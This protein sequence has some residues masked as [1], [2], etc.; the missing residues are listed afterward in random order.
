MVTNLTDMVE[1]KQYTAKAL[2]D[3]T[4]KINCQSPATYRK[5]I[6]YLR[7]NNAIHHTYQ[8]ND[9]YAF[10]VI[11]HTRKDL[12]QYDS[13]ID[14]FDLDAGYIQLE[15]A[16]DSSESK[17]DKE[18]KVNDV[19]FDQNLDNAVEDNEMKVLKETALS[20]RTSD[21]GAVIKG[22]RRK[23]TPS[24]KISDVVRNKI[25]KQ[26][27]KFPAQESHYRREDTVK[28]C[29]DS[30]L[31]INKRFSHEKVM[32]KSQILKCIAC[33]S[34]PLGF[35]NQK[36]ATI[37]KQLDML[38]P[39]N[40]KVFWNNLPTR[41]EELED[42]CDEGVSQGHCEVYRLKHTMVHLPQT[43]VF[44]T[45]TVVQPLDL[46]P[47]LDPVDTNGFYYR[48]IPPKDVRK[49]LVEHNALSLGD[50]FKFIKPFDGNRQNLTHCILSANSAFQLAKAGQKDPL[51]HYVFTKLSHNVS[52]KINFEEITSWQQLKDTLKSYYSIVKNVTQ[53]HEELETIRQRPNET[54]TEY[55]KKLDCIKNE[56]II[57]ENNSKDNH[58]DEL[59]AIKRLIKI[60]IR[61]VELEKFKLPQQISQIEQQPFQNFE[62]DRV[63]KVTNSRRVD[64]L[65]K[66]ERES[67]TQIVSDSQ[68]EIQTTSNQPF[69]TKNYRYPKI[70]EEEVKK[71]NYKMLEQ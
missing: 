7:E 49:V 31:S 23:P 8:P 69:A 62:E 51:L 15:S 41:N 67:L 60:R 18:N 33:L 2:V 20:K 35:P 34:G 12:N 11:V 54:I 44:W 5:L 26:I 9:E 58:P 50:L 36:K 21:G 47:Q 39:E 30:S 70:Y 52:N 57:A 13:R 14:D 22:L 66:K 17:E 4:I 55:F 25:L 68:H 10:K 65:N 43:K 3:N 48:P 38:L 59:P 64:H 53:L 46:L 71:Q 45:G 6:N 16:D 19:S 42:S 27:S 1:I 28:K 40:W 56:C 32:K 63:I 29:L 24:N 37:V 61:L